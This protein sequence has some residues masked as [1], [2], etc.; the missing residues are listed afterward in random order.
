MP[1]PCCARSRAW[2]GVVARDGGADVVRLH[3]ALGAQRLAV[4]HQQV[5]R[6][7][8]WPRPRAVAHGFFVIGQLHRLS[9]SQAAARWRAW[10]ARGRRCRARCRVR[11]RSRRGANSSR[12]RC[13]VNMKAGA[14]AV[15]RHDLVAGADQ[16]HR[17][18][19]D[20]AVELA[21]REAVAQALRFVDRALHAGPDAVPFGAAQQAQRVDQLR[22]LRARRA[23][24]GRRGPSAETGDAARASR[25]RGAA[26]SIDERGRQASI[27]TISMPSRTAR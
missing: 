18:R 7:L 6:L 17:D 27:S 3:Q 20:L 13:S 24:P 8:R 26:T 4:A 23:P 5:H 1:P 21:Q 16:R 2:N 9:W 14:A 10:P 22:A 11:S 12:S 19:V 25:R 15:E